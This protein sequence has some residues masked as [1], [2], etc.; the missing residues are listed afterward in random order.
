MS[1]EVYRTTGIYTKGSIALSENLPFEE[2]KVVVS[3]SSSRSTGKGNA[4]EVLKI[5]KKLAGT[6]PNLP[7]GVKYVRRLRKESD[8]RFRGL[9]W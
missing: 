1:R 6:M 3:V 5:L 9:N 7:E 4:K 8:K 2:G